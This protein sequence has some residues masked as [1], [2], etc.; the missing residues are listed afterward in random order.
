MPKQKIEINNLLM[1]KSKSEDIEKNIDKNQGSS[2]KKFL[3]KEMRKAYFESNLRSST[4][5][6]EENGILELQ[7]QQLQ[8]WQ[9]NLENTIQNLERSLEVKDLEI[10]TE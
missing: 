10:E 9:K 1:A 5:E 8:E 6:S 4:V 3:A 7:L 2:S